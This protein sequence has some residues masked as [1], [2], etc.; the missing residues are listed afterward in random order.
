MSQALVPGEEQLLTT[1]VAANSTEQSVRGRIMEVADGDTEFANDLITTFLLGTEETMQELR[2]AARSGDLQAL[3]RGAH[4]LKG[5]AANLHVEALAELARNLETRA[6]AGTGGA[7]GQ[8]IE[9]ITQ[10]FNRV[11]EALRGLLDENARQVG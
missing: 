3:A 11:S 2:H 5:A 1:P 4:K 7:W 8:E 9:R 6:K 10:E